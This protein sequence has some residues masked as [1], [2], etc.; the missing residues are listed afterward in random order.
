MNEKTLKLL[1]R[2]F[3]FGVE[4]L[5]FLNRL[6]Y[7]QI[8]KIPI[9]QLG[10]SATSVGANY[11]EAQGAVSKR[12]FSYKISISY[13]EIKESHYGLRILKELYIDEK[14]SI[15]FEYFRNEAF[16]LEKIFASIKISA[17]K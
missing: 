5:K 2:T 6:P 11:Q 16:E 4:I 9:L 7:N 1:E 10:R 15:E 8:Y 14:F 3:L 13:K 17:N 12:D